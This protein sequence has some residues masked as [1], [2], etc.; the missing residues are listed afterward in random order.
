V[1]VPRHPLQRLAVERNRPL[2]V[3]LLEQ[4][5]RGGVVDRVRDL[6]TAPGSLIITPASSSTRTASSSRPCRASPTVHRPSDAW[7]DLAAK[8]LGVEVHRADARRQRLAVARLAES[9][10]PVAGAAA[11]TTAT[12]SSAAYL[13][14]CMFELLQ[15]S[16][17]PVVRMER[18]GRSVTRWSHSSPPSGSP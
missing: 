6:L 10:P 14:L 16:T 11:V 18:M 13:N 15:V 9:A 17:V 3:G 8:R 2:P 5:L 12:A 1:P 7:A 4:V